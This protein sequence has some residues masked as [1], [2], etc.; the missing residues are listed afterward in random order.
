MAL[1]KPIVYFK[2]LYRDIKKTSHMFY[3]LHLKADSS[4][5]AGVYVYACTCSTK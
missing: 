2:V 1:F 3:V 4:L 5:S